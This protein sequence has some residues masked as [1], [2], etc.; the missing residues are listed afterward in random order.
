MPYNI[1]LSN[2][3]W[4]KQEERG[5]FGVMVLLS[6]KWLNFCLLMGSGE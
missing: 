3:S 5:A 4:G 1:T 2:K 6:W